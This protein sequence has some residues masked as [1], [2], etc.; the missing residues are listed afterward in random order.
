MKKQNGVS[1][2]SSRLGGSHD[3]AL[4]TVNRL[5]LARETIWLLGM[6]DLALVTGGGS[7]GPDTEV[8]AIG[9]VSCN[10]K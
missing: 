9:G 5:R 8:H 10:S 3:N 2:S 7:G 4:R 6:R 1:V